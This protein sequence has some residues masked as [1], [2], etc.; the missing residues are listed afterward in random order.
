[1]CKDAPGCLLQYCLHCRKN[2]ETQQI[3]D[4]IIA[5]AITKI[6]D[7]TGMYLPWAV[8]KA[9]LPIKLHKTFK[10]NSDFWAQLQTE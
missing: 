9:G 6:P 7:V 3:N 8:L 10:T 5:M 1:M 4:W 2:L